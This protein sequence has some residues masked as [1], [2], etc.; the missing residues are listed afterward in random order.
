MRPGRTK[1]A[2]DRILAVDPAGLYEVVLD[3]DI[4]MCGFAPAVAVLTACR[5]AG[6]SSGH[7]IRY[8]NSGEAS[9]DYEQSGR[10]CG[11]RSHLITNYE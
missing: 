9:G 6:A 8:T 5:D 1:F 11:N 2:I 10:V 7:L 3:K 4:T